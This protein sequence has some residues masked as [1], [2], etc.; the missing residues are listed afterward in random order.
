MRMSVFACASLLPHCGQ[1][2]RPRRLKIDGMDPRTA[3]AAAGYVALA[4][5]GQKGHRL[6]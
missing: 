3:G 4:R 5:K 2:R 6:Y 1:M